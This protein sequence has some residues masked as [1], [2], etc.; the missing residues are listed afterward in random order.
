MNKDT[1]WKDF[2]NKNTIIEK[3]DIHEK[4]GRTINGI[5]IGEEKWNDVLKDLEVHLDLKS[6]DD[7]LDIAAGSGA[8]AIYY[9]KKVGSYTALDISEK[10]IAGLKSYTNLKAIHGD[11]RDM[12][13][14]KESYSK[15]ILYFALQHFTEKETLLL[16]KNIFYWLKAGGIC[17]IGDIPDA[18]RKFFFFN[19]RERE[20]IYFDSI[21]KNSPI[22]GTWFDKEFMQKAGTFA[23][24]TQSLILDQPPD[25]I[26][27]HYRFD[28]KLVK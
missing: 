13:F 12:N 8:I 3:S 7:V 6:T 1:Y 21:L 23:G 10:L 11:V 17:F 2:W 24:F 16:L 27:A 25:Y 9:R 15:V 28:L 18:S 14:P 20:N 26:N 19:D 4:V 5:P 22:V